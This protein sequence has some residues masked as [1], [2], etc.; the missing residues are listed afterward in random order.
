MLV[1]TKNLQL[2]IEELDTLLSRRTEDGTVN[3]VPEA[4]DYINNGGGPSNILT[5]E[6]INNICI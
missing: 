3:T 4:F 1:R 2:T 5:D 6:D